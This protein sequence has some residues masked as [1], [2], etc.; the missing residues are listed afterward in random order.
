MHLDSVGTPAMWLGFILFVIAMLAL[1]LGV[2]HRKAHVVRMREALTWSAVWVG[3]AL[4]FN[5][6]VYFWFGSQR[7][8]E[9]LTAYLIEETLSVDNLFVF[10]V[11]F[12]YFAVP[13]QLQ[14]RVLFWGIIGAIVLRI[15]FILAGA[16]LLQ[17]FHWVIY[18][19][20]AFLVFTGI[21][22]LVQREA[23]VHPERNPV[24]R[25]ARR[26]IPSISEYRGTKFFVIENGRRYAT[27]LLMV[28]LVI[29]ATDVV[30]AV[31]SIPAVFAVTEDPF[32]VFTSNIFAV[33]GLRSLYF[34]LAGMMEKFHYLKV[35]L[36]LVLSFV[37]AKMLIA[38]V[39]KLPIV[40]SLLVIASL[41]GGSIVASLLR[42]PAPPPLP[43]PDADAEPELP[44]VVPAQSESE[45][46]A[47]PVER[48]SGAWAAH[49]R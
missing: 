26:V 16:A 44:R 27:P 40:V 41:L 5:V 8:L 23:E 2:F 11:I 46:K 4:A 38:D 9:F 34:A 15:T 45:A 24:L 12:G 21:K 14:H 33:L 28:L 39:Y 36:G 10:L 31:D 29:E 42:P 47:E 48:P 22:L 49:K 20:G 19:F 7:A 35:G 3:L 32:I 25:I 17:R 1:D 6:G 18:V 30:F 37:G 43:E 13:A